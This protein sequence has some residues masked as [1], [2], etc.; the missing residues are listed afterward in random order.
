MRKFIRTL[1]KYLLRFLRGRFLERM[2]I[3]LG[4]QLFL[5]IVAI[6]DF[7]IGKYLYR[8]YLIGILYVIVILYII[9]RLVYLRN[10][11]KTLN[12][13]P[14]KPPPDKNIQTRRF[15]IWQAP[16]EMS[17]IL[18]IF[19]GR[20]G[21]FGALTTA[22]EAHN[23]NVVNQSEIQWKRDMPITEPPLKSLLHMVFLPCGT[24]MP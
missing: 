16:Q 20:L 13:Q 4:L 15:P 8:D 1:D 5:S 10:R 19:Y 23:T 11:E 21:T 2:K 9:S 22:T 18:N 12:E 24:I 7:C 14:V 6:L 17:P 3:S